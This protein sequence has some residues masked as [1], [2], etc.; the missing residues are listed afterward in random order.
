MKH[1]KRSF[2][3]NQKII[4]TDIFMKIHKTYVH[5]ETGKRRHENFKYY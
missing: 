5:E 4:D 2:V 1:D 3:L